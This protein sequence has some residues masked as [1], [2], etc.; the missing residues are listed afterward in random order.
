[1]GVRGPGLWV[2][3]ST[4]ITSFFSVFTSKNSLEKGQ[5]YLFEKKGRGLDPQDPSR[6]CAPAGYHLPGFGNL[7]TDTYPVSITAMMIQSAN[8]SLDLIAKKARKIYLAY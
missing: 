5:F 4:E 7:E 3:Y 2:P 8:S 1:M 6:S